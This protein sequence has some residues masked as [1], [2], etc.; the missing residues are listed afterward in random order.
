VGALVRARAIDR[1]G[2]RETKRKAW[3]V[4]SSLTESRLIVRSKQHAG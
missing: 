1:P 2:L 4:K 3:S